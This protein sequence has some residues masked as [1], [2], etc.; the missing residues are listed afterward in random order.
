[1]RDPEILFEDQHLIVISKP[2]GL[3]SQGEKRGD[4]NLVDWL[5]TRWNRP[6]VGLVH[7]LD[8]NTSGAM[9]V[10]KRT[11]AAHRLTE[12]LQSGELERV[13]LAWLV[14][15]LPAPAR[16]KHRLWKDT[17]TNRTLVVS[18]THP[19]GKDATLSVEPRGRA[20]WN[21]LELTL[22][23]FKLETGRS[24]QIRVQA[25]HEGF[26]LLG[27]QKYSPKISPKASLEFKRPALHSWRIRF[28]H[29]MSREMLDF[30]SPLPPDMHAI[31][32]ILSGI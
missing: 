4:P 25:S 15:H 23:E 3:L 9:V 1:M 6:Y 28:P 31:A 11:K 13:Y 21:G 30:E 8:R 16:W 10:A 22:A 17:T 2:V 27:D 20:S 5:R 29:P 14:G 26:P 12:S 7:R 32:T 19:Q 18:P 24:H